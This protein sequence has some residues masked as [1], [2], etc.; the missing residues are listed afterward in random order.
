MKRLQGWLCLAALCA[1][2]ARAAGPAQNSVPRDWLTWG[3]DQERTGWNQGEVTLTKDN[4]SELE[5]LWKAQ[6]STKP[7]E[8]VLATLTAP[9]V[10]EGVATGRGKKNLLFVVGSDDTVFAMDADTGKIFW[11]RHFQNPLKPPRITTWLCSNTQNA[12]PVIDRKRAILYL[13]TSDGMLRGLNL[14]DGTNRSP[15]TDFVTPFARNVSLNLIDDV[16]YTPTARGCGGAISNVAAMDVSDPL[17]PRLSLFYL[18]GGRPAGPWGRGG[19]VK[20]PKGVYTQTADGPADPASGVSA[21]QCLHW[22][23]RN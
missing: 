11:R 21:K 1:G 16:I 23:S 15:P 4:V 5:L 13:N 17:H 9:L 19:V 2:A 8:M 7:S 18:S 22:R 3:Y 20:G 12:T 14:S 10:V 6:V